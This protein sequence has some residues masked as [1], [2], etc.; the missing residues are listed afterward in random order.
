[1][2]EL[3]DVSAGYAG[4]PV[5]RNVSLA[6]P[7]GSIVALLG[8]NGAGKTTLVRVASGL[9]PPTSGCVVLE[10]EDA[11]KRS[12]EW[13]V[14]RG[15]CHIPEGRGIFPSLSVKENLLL[16]AENRS[17]AT[18]V[19]SVLGRFPMLE[20][21]MDQV[22]GT[23]SGGQQQMLALARAFIRDFDFVLIDDASMGLAPKVVE[24]VFAICR[25]LTDAGRGLLLVDQYANQVSKFADFVYILDKGSIV[26]A[27]ERAELRSGDIFGH[28]MTTSTR[29]AD[30]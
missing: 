2:L 16:F 3:R 30:Q 1:M 8:A 11:S 19:D 13:Y 5:L 24:E 20:R 26:F 22:A 21:C 25:Q 14:R 7:E 27:G 29:T 18:A 23:L 10:G 6:V 4:I 17:Q 28:Y 9:H 15:V 12:T